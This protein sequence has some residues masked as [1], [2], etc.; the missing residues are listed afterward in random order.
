MA[1]V[2]IFIIG[3]QKQYTSFFSYIRWQK[4]QAE[5]KDRMT[6]EE[7]YRSESKTQTYVNFF[8][9]NCITTPY[10]ENKQTELSTYLSQQNIFQ[11]N[12]IFLQTDEN[13]KLVNS[14]VR[15]CNKWLMWSANHRS[16]ISILLAQR[17]QTLTTLNHLDINNEYWYKG[18]EK[19]A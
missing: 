14:N 8:T 7:S 5:I 4:I 3:R 11:R 16:G 2:R 10:V 9:K 1:A 6:E 13:I 19:I 17:V 12:D 15:V 18:V